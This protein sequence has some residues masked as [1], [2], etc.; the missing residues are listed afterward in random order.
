[1]ISRTC[2]VGPVSGLAVF[3]SAAFAHEGYYRMPT[4]RGDALVFCAEGDLWRVGIEGGLAHRLTT[5]LDEETHPALSPDGTTIAFCAAYEG[6]VEVYTMPL[7]GGVPVRHTFGADRTEVCGWTT[8]GRVVYASRHQ[9]TLPEVQLFTLDLED[10]VSA[11]AP[12]AQAAQGAL[13][14]DGRVAFTRY[15][16][17]GSFT[18]RYR[19]GTAREIWRWD[20]EVGTE[21]VRLTDGATG[22]A[23]APMW[24]EGRIVFVSDRGGVMNL[25]SMAADGTDARRL[26]EHDRDVKSPALDG[27]RIA[28]QLGADL[29]VYDFTRGHA[30][31]VPIELA[32]DLDQSRVRW[33]DDPEEY[34]STVHVS[35]NGDRVAITARGE[36]VVFPVGSGRRV[37]AAA[38]S[39]VRYRQATFM[40]NGDDLLVL[41]DATGEVELWTVAA[42]GLSDPVRRTG[43]GTV[44]RADPVPSPDGRHV[45]YQDKDLNLWVHDLETGQRRQVAHADYDAFDDLTW[46]PDG[47][48]LAFVEVNGIEFGTI[49]LFDLQDGTVID[50]TSRRTS[51]AHPAFSPDG[52]WLWFVSERNLESIAESVWGIY[53]PQPYF[54]RLSL[55]YGLPLEGPRRSPFRPHDELTSDDE[56]K[57]DA[58]EADA[59]K[60]D[61]DAKADAAA[62]PQLPARVPID[63]DELRERLVA[64]PLPAGDYSALAATKEHLYVLS[65]HAGDRRRRDLIALPIEAA[66]K[67]EP[68]TV[69]ERVRAFELSANREKILV[70]RGNAFVVVD[71]NGKAAKLE[72][73]NEHAVDLSGWKLAID[74]ARERRHMFIEAWRLE[75]DYFYDPGMHGVDW[76]AVLEKYL[77]L[78]DRVATRAELADLIGEMVGELSALHI[79]VSGG[80]F[81]AATETVGLGDLGAVLV[82][83][84]AGGGVRIASIYRGDEDFPGPR[85]PLARPELDLVAGDVIT[86]VN[87]TPALSAP[88]G[89]LLRDTAGR[90]VRL[91]VRRAGAEPRD[92]IVEP[93]SPKAAQDLRYT[94]WER[95]C[96]ER[97]ESWSGGRCAYIHLRSM[98][99]GEFERFARDYYPAFDRAGL[100]IDVRHN[101][102]GSMD[103]WILGRLMRRAWMYWKGRA[104]EPTWSMQS[105][106]RGKMIILCDAR[107]ASDGEAICAG[108]RRLGLGP[109]LGARTWGG[110]IWLSFSNRLVDEG[111]AS[112]AEYG[113]YGPEGAWLI[114]GHGVDPDIVVENLPHATFRGED[115]QL[116]AAVDW[117][118]AEVERDPDPVPPP[119]AYPD[120]SVPGGP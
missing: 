38:G 68:T 37:R 61:D 60:D 109:V 8:N 41:S 27:D 43:D 70:R 18:K 97:V 17:Q 26:T 49:R 16:F 24:R 98:G 28:Y 115:A 11:P 53:E 30:H 40:P 95:T 117:L 85:S 118:R 90:Q 25:W 107:T 59:A 113:V 79:Y 89:A 7:D 83:D 94:E 75:R 48:R 110:E 77:P 45:A 5:H 92:V 112:A 91:R 9:S 87:G 10:D 114:E 96:R 99:G 82:R 104:G 81:R 73:G 21:A 72:P 46:S 88:T 39:D 32:S 22:E 100:V 52:A 14:G 84:V 20:G 55:V 71:A 105:A 35:P 29:Y 102:G 101:T 62:A 86:H 3:V 4:L 2:V 93:L 47:T 36:V 80:D 56:S 111:I 74:P 119:P 78:V 44:F 31:Q 57:G 65:R 108:F 54:D 64:V 15:P 33:I 76:R 67:P 13:D 51:S 34:I 63:T 69:A 42:D 1:M 103:P 19:G 120:K 23:F 12:L 106:F 58:A 116:R 50:L 6:P 66:L